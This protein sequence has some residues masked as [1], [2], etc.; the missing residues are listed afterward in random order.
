MRQTQTVGRAHARPPQGNGFWRLLFQL[1]Y[2][3]GEAYCVDDGGRRE[4]GRKRRRMQGPFR[5]N[6]GRHFEEGHFLEDSPGHKSVFCVV[7]YFPMDVSLP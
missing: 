6:D 4:A 5:G 7:F 1:L 2:A 3:L